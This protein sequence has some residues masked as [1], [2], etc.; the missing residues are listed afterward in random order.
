MK[1]RRDFQKIAID[2]IIEGF[3]SADRGKLIMPCGSGKT[4]I[5]MWVH[6][7]MKPNH[8][9]VV[10]P[11]LALLRQTK[12]EWNENLKNP[13]PYLCVCS[14]KT[15]DLEQDELFIDKS[16]LGE[17]VST[18]PQEIYLFLKQNHK[19]IIYCTYQSLD[20]VVVAI[21]NTDYK[22]DI[23]FCDEAH[24]TASSEKGNFTLIHNDSLIPITKRLYMTA[25]PRIWD[26]TRKTKEKREKIIS[27]VDMSNTLIYGEEFYHMSFKEAIDLDILVNYRII[28]IGINDDDIKLSIENRKYLDNHTTLLDLVNNYALNLFIK[29]YNPEHTISF[30]SSIKKSE[31]FQKRH[32][33]LFKEKNIFHINS[34]FNTDKRK[35]IIEEFT[36]TKNSIITNA[37][38]LNEGVDIPNVD[39]IYFCDPKQSKVD[40]VQAI[41]RALRK[42]KDNKDKIANIII[43]IYHSKSK[44]VENKI[45]NSKF[46]TISNVLRSLSSYDENITD[47]IRNIRSYDR[48]RNNTLK[49]INIELIGNEDILNLESTLFDQIVNNYIIPF[50]DFESAK[51][52][53]NTLELQTFRDWKDYIKTGQKPLDIP[54]NPDNM[55]RDK[56]W[57]NWKDWLG[58]ENNQRYLKY[59]DAKLY[60]QTLDVKIKNS[61]DW[62]RMNSS[63]QRPHNLPYNP[64]KYYM[65]HGW[66][67]WKDFL[68]VDDI[69]YENNYW[70]FENAKYFVHKLELKNKWDYRIYCRGT[71][72]PWQLPMTPERVYKEDG[73]LGWKD[74]LEPPERFKN[75]KEAKMFATQLNLKSR[76]DWLNYRK[77]RPHDIPCDPAGYYKDKGWISWGDFLGTGNLPTQSHNQYFLQYDE[78]IKFVHELQLNSVKGVN[79]RL[80]ASAGYSKHRSWLEYCRS[81][82]KPNN[83]PAS[84]EKYYKDK[85]WITWG[86]WLGKISNK[87]E[88]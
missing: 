22:F 64:Q 50:K 7:E 58:V 59:D 85:G 35:K 71:D 78:A 26:Q 81:G 38:C 11:S 84:P 43:P 33:T 5:A 10:V 41:G 1:T 51:S 2:K 48:S 6:E 60:I 19:T 83:I 20:K 88:E 74:F 63:N 87:N 80:R 82:E 57:K 30:H 47:S 61:A 67:G 52:F 45:V 65:K 3:K 86:D 75:F 66:I 36:S 79:G 15:I 76:L 40:I 24:R 23:A 16:E 29:K 55:Y 4:L 42:S 8:T 31:E 54:S 17:N 39:S 14:E 53:V 44:E 9:L 72:R 46:K 73:W 32:I 27:I 13:L 28:A 21:N 56:G 34:T 68:G 37:R 12:D 70:T 25:T 69:P 62:R 77:N 18:D 49:D